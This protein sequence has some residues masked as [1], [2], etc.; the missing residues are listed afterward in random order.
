[1]D[2]KAIDLVCKNIYH[3]FPPFKNVRP[4]VSTQGEGRYLLLF[5]SSGETP[6]GRTI[7]ETL[8][9]VAGEDGKILKT[10]MSR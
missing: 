9:V 6:D 1:M 5:K 2:K 8:R 7:K 4:K 10:S 3:R